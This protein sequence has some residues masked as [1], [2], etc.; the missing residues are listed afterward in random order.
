MNSNKAST[1]G[2]C[3]VS[4]CRFS[5]VNLSI[6][7]TIALLLLPGLNA[8]QIIEQTGRD[9]QNEL[10]HWE[11]PAGAEQWHIVDGNGNVIPSQVYTHRHQVVTPLEGPGLYALVNLP[12]NSTLELK[13]VKGPGNITPLV[14]ISSTK[15]S[16][17]L[18]SDIL[19]VRV[20]ASKTDNDGH[21]LSPIQGIRLPGGNW[22]GVGTM[23]VDGKL[24]KRKVTVSASGPVFAEVQVHDVWSGDR[25]YRCRVRL[26]ARQPV[27]HITESFSLGPGA[28]MAMRF[29]QEVLPD[30]SHGLI[31]S[32]PG[33]LKKPGQEAIDLRQAGLIAKLFSWRYYKLAKYA[34]WFAAWSSKQPSPVLGV[35]TTFPQVWKLPGGHPHDNRWYQ[36]GPA[37]IDVVANEDRSMSFKLSLAKGTR[38]Y[39]LYLADSASFNAASPNGLVAAKRQFSDVPLQRAK[40][41]TLR[42]SSKA[43]HPRLFFDESDLPR[44]RKSLPKFSKLHKQF[45][46]GKPA[47][48]AGKGVTFIEDLTC[49]YLMTGEKEVLRLALKADDPIPRIEMNIHRVGLLPELRCRVNDMLNGDG[50]NPVSFNNIMWIAD[51]LLFRV[52]TADVALG[53]DVVSTEEKK[54]I[55]RLLATIAY[56]LESH[57]MV[58]PQSNGYQT[59]MPNM[60]APFYACLGLI[61]ALLPDHPHSRRWMQRCH[62]KL[63][64]NMYWLSRPDGA[65]GETFYYQERVLRGYVPAAIALVRQGMPNLLHDERTLSVLKA[66]VAVLTPRD[67]RNQARNFPSIGDATYYTPK[68][69]IA[70]AA[71]SVAGK[72]AQL[73]TQ[74]QWAWQ[75]QGRPVGWLFNRFHPLTWFFVDPDARASAPSLSS[76]EQDGAAL[77]LRS[78]YNTPT[79]S[80]L[81]LR[82]GS[83][84]TGHFQDDQLSL[85]WFA[86]GAPLCLDWGYYGNRETRPAD[87]HNRTVLSKTRTYGGELVERAFLP[88]LD[89]AH[90]RDC[91][92]NNRV[93]RLLFIR[94]DKPADPEY[95]LIRDSI[96]EAGRWN[97]WT[98]AKGLEMKLAQKVEEEEE[99]E[100]DEEE[101]PDAAL[102][103]KLAKKAEAETKKQNDPLVRLH[104][105]TLPNSH[106]EWV[107]PFEVPLVDSSV[108]YIGKFGVDLKVSW[109]TPVDKHVMAAYQWHPDGRGE[110]Q[111]LLQL[112][113]KE[114]GDFLVALHPTIHGKEQPAEIKA[115][116]DGI[117]LTRPDGFEQSAW[118]SAP[119]WT[120]KEGLQSSS[121]FNHD[122]VKASATAFFMNRKPDGTREYVLIGGSLLSDGGINLECSEKG[123]VQ[124]TVKDSITGTSIGPAR[125]IRIT[126]AGRGKPV[127]IKVA[128]GEQSFQAELK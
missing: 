14:R 3:K 21:V 26:V 4:L 60:I 43:R 49:R 74:L 58:P 117:R 2:R 78:R 107:R 5:H 22:M 42:W 35:F 23:N 94:G 88:R 13:R 52:I 57:E 105:P 119:D 40:D 85:H 70:W 36:V 120:G 61:G 75:Q 65:W 84:A 11:L 25:Q 104:R 128:K 6:L 121:Q 77:I 112:H 27:V 50:L 18:T 81:H 76:Q 96:S 92:K 51:H 59:G 80:Y 89:Y 8:Q 101:D 34:S 106:G 115:W 122:N 97:L 86:K 54:E 87:L 45:I 82:A 108:Q 48:E 39:C 46:T 103:T 10:V 17:T 55:R 79:E 118:M 98:V 44:L 31:Q 123:S 16:H 126:L 110:H 124:V 28:K 109:F 72:D 125:T 114:A 102:L 9:W 7:P 83:F 1:V 56:Q 33:H 29:A 20:T 73:A 67:P 116:G 69:S 95:M 62:S 93:R 32:L 47:S 111:K 71:K 41:W 53:A 99:E 24:L 113:R 100:E 38:S 37:P 63:K 68:P 19:A 127:V 66:A 64:E 91:D 12:A 15:D 90:I 30:T